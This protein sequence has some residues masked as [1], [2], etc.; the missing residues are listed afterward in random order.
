VS[1]RERIAQAIAELRDIESRD[2]RDEKRV[3]VDHVF[4][5]VTMQRNP[6][7]ITRQDVAGYFQTSEQASK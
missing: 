1:K 7:G 6:L 3:T 5:Y 2:I 4:Y